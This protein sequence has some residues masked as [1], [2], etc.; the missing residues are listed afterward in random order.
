MFHGQAADIT[1]ELFW[2]LA[3]DLIRH[4]VAEEVVVYPHLRLGSDEADERGLAEQVA[5]EEQ[6]T[7][8]EDLPSG[9]RE[10]REELAGLRANVCEHIEREERVLLSHLRGTLSED[11]RRQLGHRYA[12]VKET[13]PH[14][15]YPGVAGSTIVG[16]VAALSDWIRDSASKGLWQAS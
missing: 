14:H 6:L 12:E 13:A 1:A 8:M 10:F 5:I 15:R 7:R 4:E 16:R 3:D 9:S 2:I 11:R